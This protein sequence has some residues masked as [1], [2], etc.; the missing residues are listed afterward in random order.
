LS[1]VNSKN[2]LRNIIVFKGAKLSHVVMYGFSIA[3]PMSGVA[4]GA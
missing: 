1:T 4:M 3:L 2:I